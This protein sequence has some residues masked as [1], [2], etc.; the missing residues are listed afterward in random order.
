MSKRGL[1][2][3]FFMIIKNAQ[4]IFFNNVVCNV[5]PVEYIPPPPKKNDLR[6][7]KFTENVLQ[8]IMPLAL[9]SVVVFQEFLRELLTRFDLKK[10]K[11]KI[12][13]SIN[14]KCQQNENRNI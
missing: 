4:L 2:F 9:L 1:N 10:I 13:I 11:I 8:K 12:N 5:M 6:A 14:L 7:R 3:F